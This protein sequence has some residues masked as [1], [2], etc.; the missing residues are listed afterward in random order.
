MKVQGL[1]FRVEGHRVGVVRREGPHCR[2]PDL[3]FG[4]W[5]SEL[6]V[7]DFVCR[8]GDV[9]GRLEAGGCL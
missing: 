1:G 3:G 2:G 4:L 6:M 8:V 5:G 7:Q 9:G